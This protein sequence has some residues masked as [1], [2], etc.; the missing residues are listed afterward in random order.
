MKSRRR[1]NIDLSKLS[2]DELKAL[3]SK[4]QEVMATRQFEE[5]LSQAIHE[6]KARD[7]RLIRF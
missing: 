4:A 7:P 2:L 3:I 5:G 1:L 6:Y